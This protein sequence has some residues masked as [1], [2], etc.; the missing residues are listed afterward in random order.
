MLIRIEYAKGDKLLHGKDL[1]IPEI[2]PTVHK[3]LHTVSLDDFI[4]VF[5]NTFD[6]E[7]LPYDPKIKVNA[8][9]DLDTFLVYTP[10]Y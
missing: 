6:Y 2:K 5:C 1:K 10:Q 9:I 4:S 3:I 7:E 8:V